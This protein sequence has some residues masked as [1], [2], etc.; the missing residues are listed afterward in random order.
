MQTAAAFRRG[1]FFRLTRSASRFLT[2]IVDRGNEN[3]AA[4]SGLSL[5]SRYSNIEDLMNRFISPS[6]TAALWALL[7][8]NLAATTVA[9]WNFDDGTPAQL[10]SDKPG[11]DSSG[12]GNL[13]RGFDADLAPAYS[14]LGETPSGSGLSLDTLTGGRDGFVDAATLASWRPEQWT[15]EATV[16]LDDTNGYLTVIGRDGSSIGGPLSDFYLQKYADTNE[17]RGSWRVDFL[18]VAGQRVTIDTAFAPKPQTWYQL[19]VTSDG[20]NVRFYV[21]DL[22]GSA[23][24]QEVG[25]EGLTGAVA[26]ANALAATGAAWTFGRGWWNGILTNHVDG[27]IDEVRFSDKALKISQLIN[28]RKPASP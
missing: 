4:L 21:N 11:T 15:I 23:G 18:T 6:F 17:G 3:R 28:I 1:R 14:A 27:K 25:S 20:A 19:A 16:W 2:R 24:Y 7:G 12:C 22:S 13:M 26:A 5:G 9:Y 10:F 8:G